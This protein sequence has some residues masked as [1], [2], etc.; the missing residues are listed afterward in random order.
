MD[1]DWNDAKEAEVRAERGHG[2][3]VPVR[4]FTGRVEEWEDDREDYGEVRM[5][6]VG[7][8]QG[9]YWTV[10]YTDRVDASGPYRWIITAWPAEKWERELWLAKA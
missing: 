6:A 8:S 2:F 4:I 3:G 1:F 9:R 10:V 5:I 7:R